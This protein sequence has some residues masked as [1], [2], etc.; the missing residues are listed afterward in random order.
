M[1]IVGIDNGSIAKVKSVA[2]PVSSLVLSVK[3]NP[4]LCSRF[5]PGVS[6]KDTFA[7]VTEL[8]ALPS[9]LRI[10]PT[11]ATVS[12][13]LPRRALDTRG[14]LSRWLS[15]TA[16]TKPGRRR[17]AVT[18]VLACHRVLPRSHFTT[19]QLFDPVPLCSWARH[20]FRVCVW[21]SRRANYGSRS[22]YGPVLSP[23]CS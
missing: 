17:E 20:S 6:L 22:A 15:L 3:V 21:N 8:A 9:T 11:V 2:G 19:Q 5:S 10:R 7:F 14:F 18:Q 13:G 12:T 16:W 1:D 4:I 23:S